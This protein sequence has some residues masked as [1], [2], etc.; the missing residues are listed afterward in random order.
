M[1]PA[2]PI[3][4]SRST[5]KAFR[6]VVLTS[7]SDNWPCVGYVANGE[8]AEEIIQL[9]QHYSVPQVADH[10]LVERLYHLPIGSRIPERF[11][12]ALLDLY[13]RIRTKVERRLP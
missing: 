13:R 3:V 4:Q 6:I 2:S 9:A 10:K 5:A 7:D 8:D 12:H 1:S 11:V